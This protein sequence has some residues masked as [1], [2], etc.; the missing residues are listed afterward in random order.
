MLLMDKTSTTVTI[1]YNYVTKHT[2]D[3]LSFKIYMN[4]YNNTISKLIN[5]LHKI[6]YTSKTNT[7][8]IQFHEECIYY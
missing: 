5:M 6:K 3:K 2:V 7:Q 4:A 1:I 8:H